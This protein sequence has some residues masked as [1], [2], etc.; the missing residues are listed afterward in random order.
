MKSEKLIDAIGMIDDRYIEEAHAAPK[1]RQFSFNWGTVSRFAM[2]A[3]CLLLAIT[4]LPKALYKGASSGSYYTNDMGGDY[5]AP[6]A[7]ESSARSEEAY[8]DYD[9]ADGAY[10]APSPNAAPLTTTSPVK[11]NKKLI[12]T[13][14]LNMETMDLDP[15]LAELNANIEKYGAYI[16]DSSISTSGNY[17]NY[18]AT[19]R[20][21]AEQYQSFLNDTEVAGNVTYYHENTSDITDTY[22]D[23]DA[24]LTSLKAEEERVLDFYK[25]AQTIEDL[26]SI[27]A[28]L[29]DIRYEIDSISARLKN[30]DLL[31]AYSTLNIRVTETKAY[32]ETSVSFFKRVANAFTNGWQNFIGG[33]EDFFVDIVYYF[34]NIV[35]IAVLVYAAYRI[36]RYIRKRRNG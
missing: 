16:Q 4:L 34:W 15:L 2:A 5:A 28:R 9:V 27:E 12:V 10:Y 6:A 31:V 1:K 20:I 23:L 7:Y 19:I 30:Y 36:Y 14:D 25:E 21:P 29:T 18:Y 26:M 35:L 22:T 3:A 17:R 32:T 24:R 11:E 8:Y 33:I 13:G